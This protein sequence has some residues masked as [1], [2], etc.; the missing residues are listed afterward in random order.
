MADKIV[1]G[2]FSKGGIHPREGKEFSE[3]CPI[4]I[5]PNPSEL[6]IAFVQHI[7]APAKVCVD[8]RAELAFG[9][10]V[11][12][13]AGYVSVPVA[14]PLPGTVKRIG[15]VT[16]PNGR[17]VPA[18]IES[19]QTDGLDPQTL[20]DRMKDPGDFTLSDFDSELIRERIR[21]AGLVGQGGAAF[22]VHVKLMPNDEKPISTLLVNG[23]ECEPYL[24]ADHRAMLEMTDSVIAG[25]R[26][27]AKACNAKE[28]VICIEANKPDAIEKISGAIEK[29][30]NKK[31]A[32]TGTAADK[33]PEIRV[34]CMKTKYPQGGE[35]QLIYAA[36]GRK[37]PLGKL[38]IEVGATVVN[39]GSAVSIAMAV[40]HELPLTHRIVTVT[41]GGITR[42][43]NLFVPIGTPIQ[44][45]IEH[46]G[47]LKENARR[48]LLGGPMM[49][50]A[51]G[52]LEIP[53]TKGTS[54]ITVLSSEE[55]D[56]A[57]ETNCIRCGRCVS[58]CPMRLI[59]TRL[60][61]ASRARN[62]DVF[63]EYHPMACIECGCCSF[64]CPAK[65]PIVQLIR[66]GKM[67]LARQRQ[68]ES[69]KEK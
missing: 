67:E 51:V 23:C 21:V 26:L 65:I 13:A 3:K 7:G 63:K 11:A 60:M 52:S 22:P 69:A 49:G 17:R 19:V 35:K 58:A 28:I 57:K 59:P 43:A 66:V 53:V 25:A 55:T 64:S 37:V 32:G 44:V 29:L 30:K 36:L 16:L 50:F 6:R 9:Q 48:V 5:L 14:A 62:W 56:R 42:P 4:E 10:P 34:M 39:V 12:E 31:R 45:L 40:L 1:T 68:A 61:Y 47:G 41:G 38:P 20:L 18:V 8:A 2:T 15:S 27:A 46:C 33:E 24:T 54:G